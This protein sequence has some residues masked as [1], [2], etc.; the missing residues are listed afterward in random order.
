MS[1]REKLEYVAAR[2][3]ARNLNHGS[4]C[5]SKAKAIAKRLEAA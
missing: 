5:K 4:G 3:R 2:M 1:K